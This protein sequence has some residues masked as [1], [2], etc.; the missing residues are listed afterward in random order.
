MNIQ[1]EY[2][3]EFMVQVIVN[4]ETIDL[5]FNCLTLIFLGF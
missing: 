5:Y 2:G 4:N 1:K 3:S